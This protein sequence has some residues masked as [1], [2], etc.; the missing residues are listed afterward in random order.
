MT[1]GW[2]KV[3]WGPADADR[4][5][6]LLPGGMCSARSYLELAQQPNLRGVRLVS[7]TMPGHAGALA[8]ADFSH[9]A[10]GRITADLA[11]EVGADVVVGFSMGAN[12]ALEMVE[13]RLFTGPTVLLG[14]SLSIADESAFF[15]NIMRLSGLIGTL[16]L[17]VLK[18]GAASMAKKAPLPPE[19]RAELAADFR[20]NDTKAMHAGLREYLKWLKRGE[21]HAAMLC[22]SDV[23]VWVVHAEKGDGG[24]TDAE[25]RTLETCDR[26]RIVTIA[27]SV[28][29][30]PNE[31]PEQIA[32]VVSEAV[33][34]AARR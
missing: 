26:I 11:A 27:G 28:F 32:A 10:Y 21:D 13:K 3:E 25:R 19:R 8:P 1:M 12:V 20:R 23:P 6:L 31:V 15:V 18:A 4:T 33:A 2:E 30:L 16:P 34:A 5:V 14:I 7:V 24:L 29:F 22:R 17:A 9:E